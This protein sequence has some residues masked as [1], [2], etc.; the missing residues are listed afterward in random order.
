MLFKYTKKIIEKQAR[1]EAEE[2]LLK[3]YC[4]EYNVTLRS[5][6]ECAMIICYPGC[7][8]LEARTQCVH[9]DFK[10]FELDYDNTVAYEIYGGDELIGCVV[11]LR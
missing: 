11:D 9:V 6:D 4:D 2:R 7:T 8:E 10:D 1:N 5:R 3:L